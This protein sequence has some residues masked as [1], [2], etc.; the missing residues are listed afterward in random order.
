MKEILKSPKNTTLGTSSGVDL[1]VHPR[2]EPVEV[3]GLGCV[4]KLNLLPFFDSRKFE[5][6]LEAGGV[7][8]DV[9]KSF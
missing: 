3:D 5:I 4:A 1:Q 7:V 6:R 2:L 9:L 8:L